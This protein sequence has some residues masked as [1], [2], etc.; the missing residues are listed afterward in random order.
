MIEYTQAVWL[1]F[2]GDFRVVLGRNKRNLRVHDIFSCLFYESMT[3]FMFP[4]TWKV[5]NKSIFFKCLS[6]VFGHI[7]FTCDLNFT[8]KAHLQSEHKYKLYSRDK[9]INKEIATF[10]QEIIKWH[11]INPLMFNSY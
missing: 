10:T 11:F 3:W 1:S 4:F 2:I 6:L 5:I 8:F 9:N 7:L